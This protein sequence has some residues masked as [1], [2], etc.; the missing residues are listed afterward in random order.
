M[1]R[2]SSA[3]GRKMR[4]EPGSATAQSRPNF[5]GGMLSAMRRVQV[6]VVGVDLNQV[7]SVCLQRN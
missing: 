7:C 3:L 5:A 4:A 1:W 6:V 2:C